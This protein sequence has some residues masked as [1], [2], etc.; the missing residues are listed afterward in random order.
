ME[1]SAL[2]MANVTNILILVV[3]ASSFDYVEHLH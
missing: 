1:Q 3:S 2:V